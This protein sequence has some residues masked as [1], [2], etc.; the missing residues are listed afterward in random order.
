LITRTNEEIYKS[1]SRCLRTASATRNG[2][3]RHLAS[4]QILQLEFAPLINR[5]ISPPLRPVRICVLGVSRT[6]LNVFQVNSQVIR[7]EEK[8]LLSR[9][10]E[11]MVSLEL[12]FVKEK[13]EDGQAMY[14]LDP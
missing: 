11:I 2:D 4:S 5:I 14:R 8:A 3:F 10:V 12:R 13:T 7:P 1:L 9:L 6:W